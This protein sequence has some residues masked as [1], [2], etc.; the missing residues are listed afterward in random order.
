MHS[1]PQ[2]WKFLL[3][4]SCLVAFGLL[5]SCVPVSSSF[6]PAPTLVVVNP[7]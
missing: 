6:T 3:A 5:T 7:R 2:S 4:G 1:T